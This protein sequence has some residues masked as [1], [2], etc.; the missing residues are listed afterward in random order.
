MSWH[1]Y[2]TFSG[3]RIP[4]DRVSCRQLE[5][6]NEWWPDDCIF[7]SGR[8]WNGVTTDRWLYLL[9]P[10]T[11]K[12]ID[13]AAQL[14]CTLSMRKTLKTISH[15]NQKTNTPSQLYCTLSST[16]VRR[17]KPFSRQN[18]KLTQNTAQLEKRFLQPTRSECIWLSVCLSV[19]A[20]RGI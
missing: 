13:T 15:C 9:F 14:Y 8:N 12:K 19:R 4:V 20:K 1:G 17:S 2:P 10:T 3:M 16:C 6:R 5:R 18:Q 7:F 11:T